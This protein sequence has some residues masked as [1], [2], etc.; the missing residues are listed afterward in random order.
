MK[1][2]TFSTKASEALGYYVY[3]L[4]DPRNEKIFYIGK[5]LNSRCFEHIQEALDGKKQSDKCEHIL[6]IINSGNEIKISIL[7]HGL[8]ENEALLVESCAIDLLKDSLK[9]E[10]SGHN[11]SELGLMSIQEIETLYSAVPL[12]QIDDPIILININKMF[13]RD[14]SVNDIYEVTRKSW[15][16]DLSKARKVKYAIATY[17]GI[18][19]GVF[20]ITSWNPSSDVEGRSE[21]VGKLASEAILEKYNNKSVEMFLKKGSQNPI[22]YLLK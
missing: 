19:R 6:E 4:I 8:N 13:K 11:S 2:S 21:F 16:V 5:G 14:M 7:R 18:S 12:T 20:E 22:K 3:L 1:K 10:V 17:R 15:K 9:N